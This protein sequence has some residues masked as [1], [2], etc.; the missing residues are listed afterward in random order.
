LEPPR[1]TGL[2]VVDSI[3]AGRLDSLADALWHLALPS[4]T[5]GLVLSGV[6]TRLIR[7]NMVKTL[8]E[9]FVAAYGA[10]GFGEWVALSTP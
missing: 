7:N 8:S 1:I 2:Y 5:L 10:M 3:F 6:F 4:F 9:D